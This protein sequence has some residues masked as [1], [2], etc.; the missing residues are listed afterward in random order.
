MITWAKAVVWAESGR[1]NTKYRR[2]KREDGMGVRDELPAGLD[3][4]CFSTPLCYDVDFD[5]EYQPSA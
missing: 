4:R 3:I 2:Q 1:R 5:I